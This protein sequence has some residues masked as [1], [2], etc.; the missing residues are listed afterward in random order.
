MKV[1]I[2]MGST[3]DP[4][5]MEPAIR[6][7]EQFG[8]ETEKRIISA[9]RTPDL[10]CEFAKTARERGIGVIIAGAGGAAHVAG[11]VAGMTTVPVIG[12][13]IRTQALGGLDSLLSIVQMPG[14]VPVATMA[15]NGS[16]NAAL[17]AVQILA[18]SDPGLLAK[19]ETFRQNQTRAVL[20]ATI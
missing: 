2:I 4:E 20:E 19:L 7:L 3:S 11:V 17:L 5:V 12:V 16:K 18:L 15:I 13:P 14:G 8:V 10:M 6:T 1:A 9:H